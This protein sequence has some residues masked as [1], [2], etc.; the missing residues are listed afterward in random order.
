MPK[1]YPNEILLKPP[2]PMLI[3]GIAKAIDK[4]RERR[5]DLTIREIIEALRMVQNVL[6]EKSR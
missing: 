4:E 1:Q 2:S 6:V 3:D 5:P